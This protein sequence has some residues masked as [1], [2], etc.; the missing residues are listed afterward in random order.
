MIIFFF[1][2]FPHTYSS[3]LLEKKPYACAVML[4]LDS[5]SVY[6]LWSYVCKGEYYCYSIH[7]NLLI[8]I[9]RSFIHSWDLQ[10]LQDPSAAG[11]YQQGLHAAVAGIWIMEGFAMVDMLLDALNLSPAFSPANVSGAGQQLKR[12]WLG[13]STA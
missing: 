13:I 2:F 3:L 11:C 9:R 6:P 12:K 10:A 4:W 1:F 7:Y 5:I 8:T